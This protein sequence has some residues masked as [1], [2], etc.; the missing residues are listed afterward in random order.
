M[1]LP[2]PR[3]LSSLPREKQHLARRRFLLRIAALYASEEGHATVLAEQI[4]L[5]P[6]SLGPFMVVDSPKAVS[7]RT[8]QAIQ[9]VTGGVVR[10]SQLSV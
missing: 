7:T 8:A 2:I 6:K 4:G 1:S 9:D 3:W 5:S 10:A